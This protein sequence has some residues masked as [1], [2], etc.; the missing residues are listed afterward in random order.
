MLLSFLVHLGRAATENRVA[1]ESATEKSIDIS[2]THL[3]DEISFLG[4]RPF[5][6]SHNAL[7][8]CEDNA[9]VKAMLVAKAY[10]NHFAQG[11]L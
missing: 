10:T 1:P 2:P 7:L 11:N 8:L 9:D 3:P 5:R 4:L 6:W